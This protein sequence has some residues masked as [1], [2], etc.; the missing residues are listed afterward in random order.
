M[1][2]VGLA[3]IRT[4]IVAKKLQE[5]FTPPILGRDTKGREW[6]GGLSRNNHSNYPLQPTDKD[7]YRRLE[8][9]RI[10]FSA[11]NPVRPDLK[12]GKAFKDY[13]LLSKHGPNNRY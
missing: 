11:K 5:N 8:E 9:S 10:E 7:L 13:L 3:T 4:F 2:L 6:E 12:G 1:R